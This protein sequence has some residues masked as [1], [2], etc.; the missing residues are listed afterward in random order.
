MRADGTLPPLTTLVRWMGA[1]PRT[2]SARLRCMPAGNSVL[3]DLLALGGIENLA[4]PGL[5]ACTWSGAASACVRLNPS[6]DAR[7]PVHHRGAF[8]SAPPSDVV[9][10]PE[11]ADRVTDAWEILRAVH[12]SSPTHRDP[13]PSP[14]GP[15]I[16]NPFPFPRRA[17][18]T[19][20][21]E[22]P[23]ARSVIDA[24]GRR[25]PLQALGGSTER[26]VGLELGALAGCGLTAS[27]EPAAG[28]HWDVGPS[29][30]DNG[31][32]RAE[33]D[34]DGRVSRLCWDGLFADLAAPAV[35]A[36]VDGVAVAGPWEVRVLESGPVRARV[37]TAAMTAGGRMNIDYVLHEHDDCLRVEV[38][39]DGE[40][41]L[42]IG[43]ATEHR[44]NTLMVADELRIAPAARGESL[45]GLRWLALGDDD[46]RGLAIVGATPFTARVD[47]GL[48][49]VL[50][51]RQLSY[52]LAAKHRSPRTLPLSL[53]AQ[54]LESPHRVRTG[55]TLGSAPTSA[56]AFRFANLRSLVPLWAQ[57]PR[58]WDGELLLSE[59]ALARGRALF[60]PPPGQ[61][62]R[63]GI[64]VTVD[65]RGTVVRTLPMTPEG[66]GFHLD[67]GPGE[68]LI[69]RW[70]LS[71]GGAAAGGAPDIAPPA[72]P[73]GRRG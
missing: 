57:K 4:S 50:A 46:A 69:L 56:S 65:A 42:E 3:P 18:A 10:E 70:R 68:I 13:V 66:D 34:A 53:L 72:L 36:S 19:I 67:Y 73:P 23:Q 6:A 41:R 35:R 52:A 48:I 25:H 29:V 1:L 60:L 14:A 26:L 49:T 39:Y 22:A 43:H 2:A 33:L 51:R 58:D 17:L 15:W 62:G 31:R 8:A 55:Q 63:V 30:I 12:E 24:Y 20:A 54:S 28:A 27:D 38:A 40:G 71:V 7:A 47:D 61:G 45:R 37:R 21:L 59:Q 64:A 5:P 9:A 16:W 11:P 44:A 32:V